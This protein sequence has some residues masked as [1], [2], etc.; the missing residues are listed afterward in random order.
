[1]V[2]MGSEKYPKENHYDN[3]VSSHGGGCNAYTEGEHTVYQFDVLSQ[4][5]AEA[6]DI[7]AHCFISPL[8]SFSSA[9]REI[10]A[11]ESEFNIARMDD[12]NRWQQT[13]FHFASN[14][15]I[16]SKFSWGN[17]KSLV[18]VPKESGLDM[19]VL[20]HRFREYYY[21]PDLMKL[22]V[23]APKTLVELQ[24]DIESAFASWN[25]QSDEVKAGS[26]QGSK[27]A[28]CH[29]ELLPLTSQLL[30]Y[31]NQSP[32]PSQDMA[33]IYR[34]SPI[35][36]IHKLTLSWQLPPT[37]ALYQSKPLNI[38]S[39]I[40]GYEGPGSLF[41]GLKSFDYA[42]SL[43]AGLSGSNTEENSMFTLFTANITLSNRGLANWPHV[44]KI[45]H[46]YLDMIRCTPVEHLKYIHDENKAIDTI[47]F[48]KLDYHQTYDAHVNGLTC[49]LCRVDFI[50]E[51]EEE[52]FVERLAALMLPYNAINR[53]ATPDPNKFYFL[54]RASCFM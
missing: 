41:S 43:S 12:Y 48:G 50:D 42:N 28:K 36:A 38:L 52:E 9:D 32:V 33:R 24:A 11:I 2:F 46:S 22:V 45:F 40:L 44:V 6:L 1:M 51:E 3:F 18:D 37:V 53:L 34:I 21:T 54:R 15:P 16:A 19:E 10:D 30:P 14:N 26:N 29:P 20:L 5:F 49:I 17:K 7:F 25:M 47:K 35:K 8:L 4:H 27:R 39:S 23:L 31:V 13:L